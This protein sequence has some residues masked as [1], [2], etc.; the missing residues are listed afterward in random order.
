MDLGDFFQRNKLLF[1]EYLEVRLE[2]LKLQGVK[3]LSK[4]AGL[5]TWLM[6]VLFLV[7]FILLFLGM[8]F[9]WW[10]AELTQSNIAGFASAAGVFVVLLV[11]CIVF[12]KKLF[13]QPIARLIIKETLDDEDE[14]LG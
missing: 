4:S 6:I 1:K 7:F 11:I 14:E 3:L 9:A 8:M 10:I 2:L 13:Q 12:R 5:F